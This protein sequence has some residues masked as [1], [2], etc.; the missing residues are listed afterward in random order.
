MILLLWSFLFLRFYVFLEKGEEGKKKGENRA[1][2]MHRLVAS[3]APP[4]GDPA[5]N[6]GVCPDQELN[7]QPFQS[8]GWCPVYGATPARARG[9][10]FKVCVGFFLYYFHPGQVITSQD[11]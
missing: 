8:A 4:T 1:Q 3:S 2:E 5:C 10:V 11:V 9:S 7:L 6:P